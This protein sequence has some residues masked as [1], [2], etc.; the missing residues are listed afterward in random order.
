MF[1]FDAGLLLRSIGNLPILHFM[2]VLYYFVIIYILRIR[3]SRRAMLIFSAVMCVGSYISRMSLL[4]SHSS[5][6]ILPIVATLIAMRW[7]FGLRGGAWMIASLKSLAAAMM[8][9]LLSA[10]VL[11]GLLALHVEAGDI[12]GVGLDMLANT[13]MMLINCTM[14]IAGCAVQCVPI[15]LW[16]HLADA[17]KKS[18]RH[19]W[20]YFKIGARLVIQ[21]VLGLGITYMAVEVLAG[22]DLL[23]MI[24]SRHMQEYILLVS[25]MVAV[26]FLAI[27]NLRQDIRYIGQLHRNDTLE[28][29]QAISRSLLANLRYFRHNMVNMLYGFE[30]MILSGEVDRLQ[31]YYREMTLKC[32]LVNNENIVALERVNHPA[33]EAL[34][35]RVVNRAREEELPL[36]LYVQG[37]ARFG[38][39]LKDGELCQILG[40][41]M[42]NAVEA[43]LEAAERF[44]SVEIRPVSGGTEIIVK[45][46][47]A[48]EVTPSALRSGGKSG[49]AGHQGQ[50]LSSCYE[51]L[52]RKNHAFL[53]F[54]VTEQYVQAQLLL[55]T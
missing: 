10:L 2:Y 3:F 32:A 55:D 23:V 45:N 35:L 51:L 41:L 6:Y 47:Y 21:L 20:V 37:Q 49:K 11:N 15:C 46:T 13:R 39:G 40:V 18:G 53:N 50:G 24:Y 25:M 12:V 4:V 9:E 36:N 30:G 43:A 31:A 27:S 7:A 33:V 8:T 38:R 16:R 54:Y 42:D 14:T 34:L 52:E 28:Q 1:R 44:V 5:S 29:Q 17:I 19:S 22:D 48:G 26:L